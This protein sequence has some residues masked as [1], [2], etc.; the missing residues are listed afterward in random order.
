[1][2]LLLSCNTITLHCLKAFSILQKLYGV[3]IHPDYGGWFAFRSVMVFPHH[4]LPRDLSPKPPVDVVPGNEDR[5][6]L[7][8]LF[9]D[10]W[11]DNRFRDII[12]PQKR[13]SELQQKYFGTLP[14]DRK[15]LV[16]DYLSGLPP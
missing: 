5:L 6:K 13:Y 9:N 11:K 12:Q 16:N 10:H 1:M 7:L 2:Y 8:L 4:F 3:S 14:A 15:I